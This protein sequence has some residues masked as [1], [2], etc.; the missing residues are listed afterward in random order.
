MWNFQTLNYWKIVSLM[1]LGWLHFDWLIMYLIMLFDNNEEMKYR[2]VWL[3]LRCTNHQNI[4]TKS[5]LPFSDFFCTLLQFWRRPTRP[6]ICGEFFF[7][8]VYV[9]AVVNSTLNDKW[10]TELG[11]N[12]VGKSC[13]LSCFCLSLLYSSPILLCVYI[14]FQ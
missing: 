6:T 11:H 5:L 10:E 13:M 9:C 8:C 1:S 2:Q 3:N 4:K 12:L 14:D 7:M